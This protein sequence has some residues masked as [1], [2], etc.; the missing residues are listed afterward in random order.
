MLCVHVWT[1]LSEF[2]VD[3]MFKGVVEGS[4]WEVGV[5]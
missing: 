1:L 2:R 5:G 3:Y 4:G